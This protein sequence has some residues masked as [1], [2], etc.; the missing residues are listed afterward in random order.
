MS[1]PKDDGGPAV[2]MSL[3]DELART[4]M[5]ELI[6]KMPWMETRLGDP[7][8]LDEFLKRTQAGLVRASYSYADE[9]IVERSK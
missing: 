3:R 4:A 2:S 5:A 8:L 1:E 6:R 7:A 9:M